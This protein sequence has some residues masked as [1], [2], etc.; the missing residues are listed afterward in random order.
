MSVEGWLLDVHARH[1]HTGMVVWIVDEE[2]QAQVK[3]ASV[4][5]NVKDPEPQPTVVEEEAS[6]KEDAKNPPKVTKKDPPVKRPS[7]KSRKG[8]KDG[9]FDVGTTIELDF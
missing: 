3:P 7:P 8:G 4:E 5:S 1:D 6:A 2:G 9:G